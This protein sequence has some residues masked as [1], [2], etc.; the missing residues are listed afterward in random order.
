MEEKLHNKIA[1][2]RKLSFKTFYA[3]NSGSIALVIQ[4]SLQHIPCDFV[5]PA[6]IKEREF[7]RLGNP[8]KIPV[9]KRFPQFLLRRRRHGCHLEKTGINVP[10]NLPNSTALPGSSPAFHQHQHRQ[11]VLLNL[12][13]QRPQ[14]LSGLLQT[15]AQ[16]LFPGSFLLYV[17]FQHIA[18]LLVSLQK[19]IQI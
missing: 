13:L 12:H 9:Q 16:F 10:D 19:I 6:G 1:V 15:P 14:P 17:I 8:G 11:A 5:H 4:L 3:V 2:V 7:S 18:S